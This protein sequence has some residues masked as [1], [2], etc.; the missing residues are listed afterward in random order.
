MKYIIKGVSWVELGKSPALPY[1]NICISGR[2]DI[3]KR[4]KGNNNKKL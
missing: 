4:K 3:S 1:I 2:G